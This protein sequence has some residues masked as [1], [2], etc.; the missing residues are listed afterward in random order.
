MDLASRK[1]IARV[2]AGPA[3]P[4][5]RADPR[6][7]LWT[8]AGEPKLRAWRAANLS[9]GP[10]VNLAA[11]VLD[12]DLSPEAP[13]ACACLEGGLVQFA[14]LAAGKAFEP[15]RAGVDVSAVRFRRDGRVAL[16][17]CPAESLLRVFDTPSRRVMTELPLALR[18][19][20]LS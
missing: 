10:Q 18:P 3:A 19:D 5:V 14:D 7:L 9:P 11:R 4:V 17:A 8:A 2:V 1:S 20:H 6:G 13:L 12:F 16:V 15:V